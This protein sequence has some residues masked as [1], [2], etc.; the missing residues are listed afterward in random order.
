MQWQW[1]KLP[2]EKATG[3]A[4]LASYIHTLHGSNPFHV[5]LTSIMFINHHS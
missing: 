4:V 5:R 1:Q 3:G 2:I